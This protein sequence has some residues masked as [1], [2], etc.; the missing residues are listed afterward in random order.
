MPTCTSPASAPAAKEGTPA[1]AA[2]NSDG[3]EPLY[4][5]SM[6]G[7]ESEEVK[8]VEEHSDAAE[9]EEDEAEAE[10]EEEAE[11]EVPIAPPHPDSGCRGLAGG[12]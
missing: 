9:E 10:E 7:F 12:R 8:S 1:P 5:Q 6:E 3:E 4:A 11:A 2:E